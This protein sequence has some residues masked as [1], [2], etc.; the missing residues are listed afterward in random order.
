MSQRR[1]LFACIGVLALSLVL[2]VIFIRVTP[3]D[4][5]EPVYTSIGQATQQLGFPSFQVNQLGEAAWYP[6]HPPFHFYLLANWYKLVGSNDIEAGRLLSSLSAVL[7][8]GAAMTFTYILTRKKASTLA[9]GGILALD[10]WFNYT[11]L[12]VKLDTTATLIGLLGM[13]AYILAWKRNALHWVIVAGLFIGLAAI[14]KHV[15]GLFILA[16]ALHWVLRRGR[17]KVQLPV[18]IITGG[19]LL[20]YVFCML[21]AV[22]DPYWDAT[23]VQLKRSLGLQVSRGLNYGLTEA[24]Q[25]LAQT[26]WAF[27]GSLLVVGAGLLITT[28]RTWQHLRAKKWLSILTL[29]VAAA[30]ILLI[31][32]RLRNPHYLVFLIVPAAIR[33]GLQIGIWW[34]AGAKWRR[35]AIVF[36]VAVIT[37]NLCTLGI[38]FLQFGQSYA[39][40]NVQNYMAAMPSDM[41]VLSEE[42]V[43]ALILAS[44]TQC[45]KFGIYNTEEELRRI[46]PDI[47]ITYSSITQ[48]PP[49]DEGILNLLGAL[50]EPDRQFIG[51]KETLSILHVPEG[52][53]EEQQE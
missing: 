4:W 43:C 51:W 22:G 12:L 9:V 52:Y 33:V 2:H 34:N 44:Q 36:S 48:R 14:Y 8:V 47:I 7:T 42:P 28:V 53:W 38:R 50:G 26:Y 20:I 39:L 10:G 32:V 25:A 45:Y 19:I 16:I 17:G 24:L 30:A 35:L 6:Y 46:Q 21:V 27:A 41:V 11:S 18:L 23:F 49:S 29:W 1:F 13:T 5:D 40:Q 31:G 37:L 15:A 3:W